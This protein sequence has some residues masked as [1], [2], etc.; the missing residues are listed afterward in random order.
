VAEGQFGEIVLR[1][2][3]R[4]SEPECRKILLAFPDRGAPPYRIEGVQISALVR[5]FQKQRLVDTLLGR[6]TSEVSRSR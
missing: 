2:S 1:L 6:R 3:T 5:E 4:Y